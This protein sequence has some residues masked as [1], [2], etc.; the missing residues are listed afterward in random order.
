MLTRIRNFLYILTQ[1]LL[2]FVLD[3]NF[4]LCSNQFISGR[5]LLFYNV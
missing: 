2:F 1:S 4:K 5:K 3:E